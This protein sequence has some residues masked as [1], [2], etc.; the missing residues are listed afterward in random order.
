MFSASTVTRYN[1][2]N[3]GIYKSHLAQTSL[4]HLTSTS[5]KPICQ[6]NS[7]RHD[8][9]AISSLSYPPYRTP[10]SNPEIRIPENLRTNPPKSH[11]Q[12]SPR[13]PA[14]LLFYPNTREEWK[15]GLDALQ[16]PLPHKQTT[17]VRCHRGGVCWRFHLPIHIAH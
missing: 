5:P 4:S 7:P 2:K 11:V 17:H 13:C 15:L 1:K 8:D 16:Q 3:L 9:L 12:K 6:K 14:N 10:P